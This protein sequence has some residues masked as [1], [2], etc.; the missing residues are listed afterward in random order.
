MICKILGCSPTIK[1]RTSSI[2]DRYHKTMNPPVFT[3][4]VSLEKDEAGK[5]Y[6]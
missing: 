3:D 2:D 1:K 6:K 4:S 5:D